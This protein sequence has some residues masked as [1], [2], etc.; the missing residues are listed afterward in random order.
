MKKILLAATIL[1]AFA[2][3]PAFAAEG[4]AAPAMTPASASQSSSTKPAVK[5]TKPIK[6]SGAVVSVDETNKTITVKVGK[7]DETFEL[8]D[9]KAMKSGKEVQ[10][11]DIKSG[12]RVYGQAMNKDGK[13]TLSRLT[14]SAPKATK[15]ATKPMAKPAASPATAK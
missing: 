10:V 1:S 2:A 3:A 5:A 6:F 13:E 11:A 14:V 9:V 7:K 15:P 8:G 12:D 4:A